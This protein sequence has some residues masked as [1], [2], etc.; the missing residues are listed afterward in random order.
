MIHIMQFMRFKM[1]CEKC[2]IEKQFEPDLG[3]ELCPVCGNQ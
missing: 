1:N 3:L 2:K